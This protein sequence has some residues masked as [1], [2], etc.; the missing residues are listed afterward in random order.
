M[1]IMN[2]ELDN[3]F[4]FEDFKI[5]FS[6]PKKI[7]N[8][9]IEE[10]YLS[11]KKNFRY[12]KVNII[13]GANTSGKTTLGKAIV[14]IFRMLN[15]GNV[16][17]LCDNIRNDKKKAY[18]EIDF[19]VDE[20]TLYRAHADIFLNKSIENGQTITEPDVSLSMYSSHIRKN[21]SYETC[22]QRLEQIDEIHFGKHFDTLNVLPKFSWHFTLSGDKYSKKPL[23]YDNLDLKILETILKTID[24]DVISIIETKEPNKGFI[25]EKTKGKIV[26][27]NGKI[28]DKDKLSSGTLAGLDLAETLSDIKKHLSKFYYC[29]EEF[30]FIHS[31]I[32]KTLLNIMISSLEKNEQLFFT[33]HNR[34]LLEM[35]LPKHSFTFL[36]KNPEIEAIYPSD[37]IK[38]NDSSL[39]NAVINDVFHCNPDINKLFEI[40]NISCTD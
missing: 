28:I 10:E 21:D 7:V 36:R 37:Y 14:A 8:S 9:T 31:E 4:A 13:M 34:E 25:I 16:L 38:K 27:Q 6:Y 39:Y 11:T 1:I 22:I 18:F 26:I 19:L 3:F 17:S 15:K 32:E 30:S 5:N 24:T 33:S 2:L 40:E 29:D 20:D 23:N 35:D 12:K